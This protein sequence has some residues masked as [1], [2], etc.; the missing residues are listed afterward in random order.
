MEG[1]SLLVLL[2]LIAFLIY[3]LGRGAEM[4]VEE[5]VSLSR[6]WGVPEVLIGATIVSL[7]TTLPEAAVSVLA[8]IQGNP[9]LALGNAVGSIIC[10][11]GLILGIA[12]VIS[13]LPLRKSIVNRQGWIQFGAGIL[14]V[15]SSMPYSSM[16]EITVSGGNLPQYMGF[17]FLLL[18]IIYISISIGW[19]RSDSGPEAGRERDESERGKRPA[20]V[21][22][23]LI[24]GI[25]L[26]VVSSAILIP[27][28]E[29]T[30]VRL[31][32]PDSIIAATLVAFGTSLPE[33]VT[34]MTALRK[35]HGELALGNVIG[36][37]ILNVLFVA[38]AAASVTRGGLE[39]TPE[40]FT[41]LFPTM[42]FILVVFRMGI[43]FSKDKLGRPF[44]AILLVSYVC[45]LLLSVF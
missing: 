2:L 16:R 30:A 25:T 12:A 32:V 1:Q 24:V 28:V 27:A 38:G 17:V 40:F 42:L 35:G 4:L 43:F 45:Y 23:K 5:A 21:L 18:L 8:A 26:V 20:L 41:F 44:G 3:I 31:H 11:T 13:P 9:D 37:D 34:A 39:A 19:A 22:V 33:L 14:L 6:S 36:A 29:E 10:D 7:G 15:L